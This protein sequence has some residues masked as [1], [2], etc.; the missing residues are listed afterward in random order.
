VEV[1]DSG[2]Q[3]QKFLRA[4]PPLEFLLLSFLTPCRTVGLF[5][6]VIT[7]RRGDHLL[8]VDV[9][10]T[11]ELPDRR[12]VAPELIGVN[13]LWDVV[14]TQQSGQEGF[15]GLG[16]AVALQ[17]NFEHEAVLVHRSPAVKRAQAVKRGQPRCS[18]QDARCS[19]QDEPM[20]DPI[21]ARTHLIQMPPGTPSGFPVAQSFSE[22]WTELDAPFAEGLVE[23]WRPHG[24]P[25]TTMLT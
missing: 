22:Q 20:S 6:Q 2:M 17:Q 8:V 11:G 18:D 4:F 19:D 21:N 12:P 1:G 25:F 10:Q 9:D 23:E 7:A 16:V 3:V 13:D 24:H 14:F 5:N 15:C